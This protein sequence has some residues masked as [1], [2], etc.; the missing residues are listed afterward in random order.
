[1]FL[2]ILLSVAVIFVDAHKDAASTSESSGSYT[3]ES[4]K[5]PALP[6]ENKEVTLFFRVEDEETKKPVTKLLAEF[7]IYKQDA[8]SLTPETLMDTSTATLIKKYAAIQIEPGM[9]VAKHTFTKKGSYLVASKLS[10]SEY[11]ISD[12]STYIH[13][14]PEGPS[15]VFWMY[16]LIT[17]I[18]GA[19]I[20]SRSH[21]L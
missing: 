13:V 20:A 7:T 11:T 1:M 4:G 15:L 19:I 5:I 18:I 8:K 16:M 2:S 6:V 14:E 9:Y 17:T 10:D 3:V 12:S 21:K